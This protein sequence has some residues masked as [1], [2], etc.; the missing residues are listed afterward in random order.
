[1]KKSQNN[2][3]ITRPELRL[4]RD[5]CLATGCTIRALH[6]SPTDRALIHCISATIRPY[7][8]H[9]CHIMIVITGWYL[10]FS[11]ILVSYLKMNCI[12]ND[13]IVLVT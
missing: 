10:E 7:P 6:F 12:D 3:H 2:Q 5:V 8:G 1:M 9:R 4:K 13:F 11:H